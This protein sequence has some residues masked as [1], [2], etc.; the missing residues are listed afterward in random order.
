M[1]D[2]TPVN[3]G[4]ET[5]VIIDD[6]PMNLKLLTELLRR[7]GYQ[8]RPLTSGNAG[9][10]SIR[11]DP[12]SLVLLDIHLPDINGYQVCEQ[13]KQDP[14]TREIP[15]VFVSALNEALDKVRAFRVGGVDFI[16]KPFQTAE[17]L[18]RVRN[19]L[20]HF[21]LKQQL[22]QRVAE[23]T[24]ELEAL[25]AAYERFVPYEFLKFL[26]KDRITDVVLGDQVLRRMT[27]LF[28]DIRDFTA[29]SET[30]TPQDNFKFINAYLKRVSPI[31]RFH[32]G[33][34]DKYIGDSIMALFPEGAATN[35]LDA[36]IA[37]R[38]K[39]SAYNDLRKRTNRRT[40]QIGTGVHVGKLMMGIIGEQK[41]LQQTVISDAVNL[42]SRLET[43]TKLYGVSIVVSKQILDLIPDPQKYHMRFLDLVQVKGKRK[44]VVIYEIFDGDPERIF[45][46]KLATRADF[47][48][49]LYHYHREEFALA[50]SYFKK[51][52]AVNVQDHAAWLF[53]N[54]ATHHS[55]HGIPTDW[56][57]LDCLEEPMPRPN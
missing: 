54:R 53:L 1:S 9:L 28:T 51:V 38:E 48:M 16:T 41:R 36:T 26:S 45:A 30:M 21:Q 34:V 12:P 11:Q 55:K 33:V 2:L 32:G 14:R 3:T 56:V 49:G 57:A 17:V 42:A 31:I 4:P 8:P 44:A 46:L 35:A 22:E 40:I 5:I 29:L 52:C 15:V 19:H 47:E 27:V 6:A 7:E 39:V 20:E 18:A 24:G 50:C 13:L 23:R 37:I 43:L 10:A 25:N